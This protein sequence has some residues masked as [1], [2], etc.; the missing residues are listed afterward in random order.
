MAN[1]HFSKLAT[2]LDFGRTVNHEFIT[3]ANRPTNTKIEVKLP[4]FWENDIQLW[5][6]ASENLFKLKDINCNNDK[7]AL[8]FAALS[9]DQL[10]RLQTFSADLNFN[11]NYD[12][13]K[14]ALLKIY[15]PDRDKDL[16]ELLYNTELG[17][18]KPSQ[19]LAHMRK[20]LGNAR[21]PSILRKLFIDKLPVETRRLLVL[22]N[23]ENIDV[24][25]ENAD[26]LF[27][28]DLNISRFQNSIARHNLSS[29]FF[30]HEPF[31]STP[32]KVSSC[33]SNDSTMPRARRSL[34][35]DLNNSQ[36]I[37]KPDKYVCWYHEKY[38]DKA[39]KCVGSCDFHKNH[40]VSSPQTKV[41][42]N[43]L[44][45]SDKKVSRLPTIFDPITKRIFLIDTGSAISV[46][47][48]NR[49]QKASHEFSETHLS[50]INGT[51][52]KTF[53]KIQ[54]TLN[55]G[56]NRTFKWFFHK[57]ESRY[58]IIG[59]D[60]LQYFKINLVFQNGELVLK[61]PYE[62]SNI[63]KSKSGDTCLELRANETSQ[64]DDITPVKNTRP[65][66]LNNKFPFK[67][68]D[69]ISQRTNNSVYQTSS[70]NFTIR[71][72]DVDQPHCFNS[73][74]SRL[75]ENDIICNLLKEFPE[76]TNDE[77]IGKSKPNHS[78]FSI[79]TK[80]AP[81]YH[82]PRRLSP[83]KS[84]ILKNEID[85][86]VNM[87]IL[88]AVNSPWSSPAHLVPK[89]DGSWRLV[90]DFRALNNATEPDRF[91][92]PF[93]SDF[94]SQLAGSTYFSAL[95]LKKGYHQLEL[96]EESVPKTAL[97]TPFGSYAFKFLAMGLRNSQ[98]CM[99]RF[100]NKVLHG[101]DF[102]FV[103]IDDILIFSK[104]FDEH[105]KHLKLVLQR[106]R[107]YSLVVNAEKCIIAARELDFL[108]HHIS[109]SGITP[110]IDKV[111][112]I[113][114]FQ[115]PK[116]VRALRKYLGM[117][118]FYRQFL[119]HIAETLKPLHA[120][121]S[122][123]VSK[124][125][126][127][128]F[129]KTENEAFENSKSALVNACSLAFPVHNARTQIVTDASLH[130]AGATLQQVSDGIVKPLAFFSK[131]FSPAQ[132]NY[133]TFDRELLAIVLAI[134]HFRYFVEGRQFEVLTDHKP[135][136]YI[137]NAP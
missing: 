10:R 110:L 67:E 93:L 132:Q 100:L 70:N 69:K 8:V 7:Y 65:S 18:R 12:E 44:N 120:L 79:K 82:R 29:S 2:P 60:F 50:A 114:N 116:T 17:D 40:K 64:S 87:G 1:E 11:S 76:L 3:G 126:P 127:I 112:A 55:L 51:R 39:I 38:G 23:S 71:H 102:I 104:D 31:S 135:L 109:Q 113:Q 88:A 47:P 33:S 103:Y 115:P 75:S 30:N 36:Q 111:S 15:L 125:K 34:L 32:K 123:K 48:S 80:G 83:E 22:T 28:E 72:C 25:A 57:A 21:S 107:E 91:Q 9:I 66:K 56:F 129:S 78:K 52:V 99:T 136:T 96:D 94:T 133:S 24:L 108:G 122:G 137:M 37:K 98:S 97:S 19:L 89:K 63:L 92:P 85:K 53:G 86:L 124:Y 42:S 62:K 106:F 95:D 49:N 117:L 128:T 77:L 121:L 130:S 20:L 119:P 59:H 41:E 4:P 101:L 81:V 14:N 73:E 105:L 54:L 6:K 27:E 5:F 61:L 35:A 46:V 43:N 118:N 90:G 74:A 134:K 13:L 16:D 68:C 45:S 131:N 58:A 26:K 84:Q